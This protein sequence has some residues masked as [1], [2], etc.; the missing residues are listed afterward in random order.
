M[1]VDGS[2]SWQVQHPLRQ[3]QA[4]GGHYHDVWT[5]GKQGGTRGGSLFGIFAVQPQAAR[6]H[7]RQAVFQGCLLDWGWLQLQPPASRPVRL[8]QY[9]GHAIACLHNLQQS[10]LGKFW[11]SCKYNAHVTKGRNR[12]RLKDGAPVQSAEALSART[13]TTGGQL[14]F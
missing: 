14:L 12:V 8:G 6:L 7:D 10:L 2:P 11:C 1:N 4:V 13:S 9:Q 3:Q 5:C